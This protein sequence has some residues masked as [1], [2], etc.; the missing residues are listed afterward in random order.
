MAQIKL[1]KYGFYDIGQK[2]GQSCIIFKGNPVMGYIPLLKIFNAIT[3]SNDYFKAIE[4]YRNI[5]TSVRDY[6]NFKVGYRQISFRRNMRSHTSRNN[7]EATIVTSMLSVLGLQ[8]RFHKLES[9]IGIRNGVS[10]YASLRKDQKLLLANPID[11]FVLA[12]INPR[13]FVKININAHNIEIDSSMI[14]L[15]V[16]EEKYHNKKYLDE[17]YN[18]TV[19]KYLRQQINDFTQHYGVK[20]EI[21][22]DAILKQYYTNPYSVETN[23]IFEI[24]EIDKRVK[25]RVFSTIDE[26]LI[27]AE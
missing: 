27:I 8:G 10:D 14:T 13:D 4:G 25:E 3:G 26:R 23:S 9:K 24:M 19:A 22:P 2:Q 20:V 5:L 16:S 6:V 18:K 7:P 11:V 15:F 1:D 21:V 12:M 17:N